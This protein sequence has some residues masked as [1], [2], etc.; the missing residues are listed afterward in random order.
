VIIILCVSHCLVVL[1]PNCY[2]CHHCSVLSLFIHFPCSL[3]VSRFRGGMKKAK[4]SK[5]KN[6][7][8]AVNTIE[9]CIGINGMHCFFFFLPPT[10]QIIHLFIHLLI[11]IQSL[12][13]VCQVS[14]RVQ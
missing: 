5:E 6:L 7:L 2:Q 11:L 4:V 10:Y 3:L 9:I 12:S 14:D 1:A 8:C 13:F